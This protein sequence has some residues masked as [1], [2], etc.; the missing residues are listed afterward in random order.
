MCG[1]G[2]QPQAPA[3]R[4][5]GAPCSGPLARM[6]AA[7]RPRPPPQH[8]RRSQGAPAVPP[9]TLQPL[10]PA[11]RRRCAS[12]AQ[13]PHGARAVRPA[14]RAEQ[15]GDPPHPGAARHLL[16]PPQRPP[17]RPAAQQGAAP[18]RAPARAQLDRAH[19]P[20]LPR[21][22]HPCHPYQRSMQASLRAFSLMEAFYSQPN[23][24]NDVPAPAA[25]PAA[26][27]APA[28]ASRGRRASRARAPGAWGGRW[29]PPRVGVP[30][31]PRARAAR[32]C[33]RA[34]RRAPASASEEGA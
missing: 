15:C 27:A 19:S 18:Q 24:L 28:P 34:A 5:H 1:A 30:G 21:L 14:R 12:R 9:Q 23:T 4:A 8:A 10:A 26:P 16:P 20:L 32:A 11:A 6:R 33:A 13:A 31:T 22:A 2:R 25:D 7:P 17:A 3:V 29:P